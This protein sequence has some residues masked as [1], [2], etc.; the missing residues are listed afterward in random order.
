MRLDFGRNLRQRKHRS[1]C[2]ARNR[3]RIEPLLHREDR[4][5]Q[6]FD[7]RLKNSDAVFHDTI[8]TDMKSRQT[9]C[10]VVHLNAC[11]GPHT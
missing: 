4:L 2:A 6:I 8:L 10:P 7:G 9:R 5:P 3:N 1:G 11:L